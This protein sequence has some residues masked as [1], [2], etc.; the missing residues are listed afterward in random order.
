[1]GWL[2]KGHDCTKKPDQT[3]PKVHLGNQT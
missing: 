1:V 2:K 3:M